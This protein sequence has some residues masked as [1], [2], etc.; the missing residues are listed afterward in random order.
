MKTNQI[1]TRKMGDFNVYQRTKD[2]MFNASSL[3]EQWNKHSKQKKN[4]NHFF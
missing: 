1:M 2:A 3:M 4:I